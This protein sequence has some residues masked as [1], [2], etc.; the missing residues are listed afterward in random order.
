MNATN[1]ELAAVAAYNLLEIILMT[2]WAETVK[3]AQLAVCLRL[4]GELPI[5][6]SSPFEMC[7]IF[8]VNDRSG[9]FVMQELMGMS[10]GIKPFG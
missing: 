8:Q 3:T 10:C 5:A 1:A 7:R 2:T 9:S 4:S 6:P